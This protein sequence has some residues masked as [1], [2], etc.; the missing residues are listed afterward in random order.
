MF[1]V[2]VIRNTKKTLYIGTTTDLR[3]RVNEHNEGKS[4]YTSEYD[5]WD[6]VYY[7]AYKSKIDAN[8][9]ERK[10]KQFG[11]SYGKLKKRISNSLQ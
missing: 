1:Y 6:L 8:D 3:R 9:R 10:L 5:N 11:S 2:Y 7:E 4:K